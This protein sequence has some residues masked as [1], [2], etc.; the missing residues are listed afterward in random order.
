MTIII[1]HLLKASLLSQVWSE[2][3]DLVSTSVFCGGQE[4]S[5]ISPAG[6][7]SA[8]L[9]QCK[10]QILLACLTWRP[11]L[12]RQLI[13]L[14]YLRLQKYLSSCCFK[15]CDFLFFCVIQMTNVSFEETKS[16]SHEIIINADWSF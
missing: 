12:T 13:S 8:R 1:T 15:L 2:N 14:Q 4:R 9:I 10:S 16:F 3:F 5:A 11:F 7:K 6:S